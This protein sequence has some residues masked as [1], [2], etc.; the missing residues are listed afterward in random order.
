MRKLSRI[1]AAMAVAGAFALPSAHAATIDLTGV[2]YVTYGDANS[3]SLPI[4]NYQFGFNTSNGPFT[5]PSTPGQISSL[6]VLG[7]GSSGNPVTTN[8]PG[9]DNAYETP[10]GVSGSTFFYPNTGNL[11]TPNNNG[12]SIAN[13]GANTWDASLTALRSF[14]GGDAMTFFFNNNQENSG[15]NSADQSLAVWARIWI[16]DNTGANVGLAYE[17]TN[18]DSPYNIVSGNL[19]GGGQ[20]NGNPAGY[21]AGAG[22]GNPSSASAGQTDY[23]LSGGPICVATG[24]TLTG[25]VP[26]ACGSNPA[27]VGGTTISSA[28]NHNL[29]ADRA[30]YAVVFPE[31]NAALATLFGTIPDSA[32]AD[33]TMHVDVRMGCAGPTSGAQAPWMPCTYVQNADGSTWG[34]GLNNGYEQIFIGTSVAAVCPPTDPQCAPNPTVPEPETLGLVALALTAVGFIGRRR[35]AQRDRKAV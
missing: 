27:L 22:A 15:P 24:G 3:Y 34:T 18:R 29:G 21:N 1:A 20:F 23:V 28:I 2:N 25:P 17:L 4:A 16:T 13:N 32:L 26:V 33:Y 30:A 9:V 6:T 35:K 12:A 5:V 19:P 11:N 10:S 8:T 31:L 7:T 14:L